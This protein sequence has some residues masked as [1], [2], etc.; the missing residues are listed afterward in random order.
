[1]T[2]LLKLIQCPGCRKR[3]DVTKYQP[4]DV[5]CQEAGCGVLYRQEDADIRKT[6][7]EQTNDSVKNLKYIRATVKE[8]TR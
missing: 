6:I 3:Y 7:V 5:R 2:E 4:G 1:M 8:A